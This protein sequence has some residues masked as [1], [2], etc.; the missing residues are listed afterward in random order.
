MKRW[1][2]FLQTEFEPLSKNRETART[3]PDLGCTLL[4]TQT[5]LSTTL[6]LSFR[7]TTILVDTGTNSGFYYRSGPSFQVTLL[8]LIP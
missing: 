4:E 3:L 7:L 6:F 1:P 5:I 2:D 8:Q